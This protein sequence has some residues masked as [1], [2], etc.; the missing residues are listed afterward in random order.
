MSGRAGGFDQLG[1]EPLDPPVQG[2][3]ID[4]DAALGQELSLDG[5]TSLDLAHNVHDGWAS[6]PTT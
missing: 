5:P 1:G 4:V 6:R 2:H 3:V